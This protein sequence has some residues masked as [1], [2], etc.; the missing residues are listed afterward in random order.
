MAKTFMV[1]PD[2]AV[3][4]V[5]QEFEQEAINNRGYKFANQ[6]QVD[7]FKK[8]RSDYEATAGKSVSPEQVTRQTGGEPKEPEYDTTIYDNALAA[9]TPEPEA[10]SRAINVKKLMSERDV[11]TVTKDTSGEGIGATIGATLEAATNIVPFGMVEFLEGDEHRVHYLR[12]PFQRE[13]DFG[14]T[15]VNYDLDELIQRATHPQ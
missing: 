10:K 4:K 7:E 15:S 6:A 14:V 3:V 12:R 1:R 11:G 5:D 8:Q 9:G 13:P 2:G